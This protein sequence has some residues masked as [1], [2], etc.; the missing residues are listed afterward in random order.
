MQ[1]KFPNIKVQPLLI[2][3]ND[4]SESSIEFWKKIEGIDKL[5]LPVDYLEFIGKYGEG[6]IAER[7][8][9]FPVRK[10]ID[11]TKFWRTDNP[12][13]AE[14]IFFK[15]HNRADCTYI[16]ESDGDTLIYLDGIY[17]FSIR[18]VED[19]IYNLGKT[20]YEV[21]L[22]FKYDTLYGKNDI[23]K[24]VPFDSHI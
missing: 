13:K 11:E 2:A 20:L 3:N 18:E 4:V 24:F 16:G 23:E 21:L 10:L 8:K 1:H 9:I 7:L 6:L 22:F 15:K 17:Y 14:V 12:T 5:D 19:K